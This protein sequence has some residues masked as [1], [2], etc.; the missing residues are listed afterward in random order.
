MTG[1]VDFRAE[2]VDQ[3]N[4]PISETNPLPVS[5]QTLDVLR[6]IASLL[7]PLQQ[8]TGSGS[9]R[10]SVDINSGTVTTVTTVTTV[11]TL[12]AITN[13]ANVWT[14][15]QAKAIS[16]QAYNSGIRARI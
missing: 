4:T 13:L 9:N 10:L 16:R 5:A 8:V 3:E 1:I 15:D 2:L 6:R 12:S 7:K 11:N 14:F